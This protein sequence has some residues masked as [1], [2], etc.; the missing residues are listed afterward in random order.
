MLQFDLTRIIIT[1]LIKEFGN[2]EYDRESQTQIETAID[3]VNK[4]MEED[5]QEH[6]KPNKISLLI[7][8]GY[9]DHIGEALKTP[10]NTRI[11]EKNKN[12]NKEI[13][14]FDAYSCHP[15]SIFHDC[16]NR[17]NGSIDDKECCIPESWNINNYMD[18]IRSG[19][20]QWEHVFNF[21]NYYLKQQQMLMEKPAVGL[22][23]KEEEK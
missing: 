6:I 14:P 21:D 20:L 18:N 1:F 3:Y 19:K 2:D 5:T 17:S 9:C 15:L 8:L 11:E 4:Y 7:V 23:S 13:I 12:Q 10:R 16:M 22:A